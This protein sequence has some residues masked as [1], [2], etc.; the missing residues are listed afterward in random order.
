MPIAGFAT[1]AR[2]APRRPEAAAEVD[3]RR[4]E[5]ILVYSARTGQVNWTILGSCVGQEGCVRT[6]EDVGVE[7]SW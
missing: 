5:D 1:P 4:V 6:W 3:R 7:E 2:R